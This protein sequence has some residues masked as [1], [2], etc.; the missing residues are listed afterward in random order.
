MELK[1]KIKKKIDEIHNLWILE[2]IDKFI[3]LIKK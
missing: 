2:Q 1:E 3:E